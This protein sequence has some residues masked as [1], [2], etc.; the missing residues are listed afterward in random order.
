[1]QLEPASSTAYSCQA[2]TKKTR[3]P[4]PGKGFPKSRGGCLSCKARRVKCSEDR[5][6]CGNCRR[7]DLDC[8]YRTAQRTSC[9]LAHGTGPT[10]QTP[11]S[12][13]DLQSLR[14]FHHFLVAAYP[15]LPSGSDSIWKDV[16]AMAPEVRLHLNSPCAVE[17]CCSQQKICGLRITNC[18]G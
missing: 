1:M 14:F 18:A 5:P 12:A 11:S 8:E 15:S 17:P 7:L 13:L 6:R 10:T 2:S 3:K 16:A 9:R 4:V